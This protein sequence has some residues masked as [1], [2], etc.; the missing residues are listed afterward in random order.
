MKR[1]STYIILLLTTLSSSCALK[2]GNKVN[3][4]QKD[5]ITVVSYYFPNYHEDRRNAAYHGQG[6]TEWE[7]V[8]QAQPRFANHHQ[9]NVP[10]WGYT[11]EANP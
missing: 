3:N 7:L 9:P 2:N 6:W 5:K 8:K 4:D 10:A 1:Y 11:D